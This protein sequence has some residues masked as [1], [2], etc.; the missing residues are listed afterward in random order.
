MVLSKEFK[1]GKKRPNTFGIGFKVTTAG[2]RR[3]TPID[4]AASAA[5]YQAV[6]TDSLRNS[7]QYKQYFRFD[8]KL[9]YSINARKLRHEIGVDLVNLL[10]TKNVLRISYTGGT[11]PLR[12]DYQL[13]FL[14][15]FYYR[16]DF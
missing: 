6:Y 5:A 8:V 2:G 15:V 11:N 14:P 1:W 13:G 4:V 3:Y 16:V 10:G 9:N 7:L 12:T